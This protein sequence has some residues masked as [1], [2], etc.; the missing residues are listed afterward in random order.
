LP[1]AASWK[2]GHATQAPADAVN[3]SPH[4]SAPTAA[5]AHAPVAG[6]SIAGGV[7]VHATVGDK[8]AA[9]PGHAAAVQNCGGAEL[10][11]SQH[12]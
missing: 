5:T 1:G 12:G 4:A 10:L 2:G 7:H 9:S 11:V 8:P 6:A 3:P